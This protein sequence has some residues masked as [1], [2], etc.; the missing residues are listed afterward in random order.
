MNWN[1]NFLFINNLNNDVDQTWLETYLD[2]MATILEKKGD[3]T[4]IKTF[5]SPAS[6]V[7]YCD[8]VDHNC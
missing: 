6:Y 4:T 2:P 8:Y 5:Q 1:T 7:L 3:L